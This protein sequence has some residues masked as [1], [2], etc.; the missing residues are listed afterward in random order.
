MTKMDWSK[1]RGDDSR[2]RNAPLRT[3]RTQRFVMR[4]KHA[5]ICKACGLAW[6]P[7]DRITPVGDEWVHWTPNSKCAQRREA[8]LREEA[9]RTLH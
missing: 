2:R 1:V 8:Q 4:S 3:T 5:G 7:L 9:L 6:K